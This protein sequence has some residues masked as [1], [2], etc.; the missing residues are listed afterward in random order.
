M[1]LPSLSNYRPR[2]AHIVFD[3]TTT[4]STNQHSSSSKSLCSN[5]WLGPKT[6][7]GQAGSGLAGLRDIP[8]PPCS[9]SPFP[10]YGA[11]SCFS[12]NQT[13]E[14]VSGCL[15]AAVLQEEQN[16]NASPVVFSV[17]RPLIY[18]CSTRRRL[19]KKN[20]LMFLRLRGWVAPLEDRPPHTLERKHR[21]HQAENNTP[22]TRLALPKICG[23]SPLTPGP[24]P[25]RRRRTPLVVVAA[26]PSER[27]LG[28]TRGCR[29]PA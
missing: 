1:P 18:C 28:S 20:V 3:S 26:P 13:F 25:R 14:K 15:P 29:S 10:T 11:P 19:C 24:S 5:G 9:L 27:R 12:Q 17:D 7:Q 22:A 6:R 8:P 21:T 2:D 16:P 4:C 23:A